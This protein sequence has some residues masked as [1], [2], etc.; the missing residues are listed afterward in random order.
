MFLKKP[1]LIS[2][3]FA[4]LG[5]ASLIGAP[6]ADAGGAPPN[7]KKGEIGYLLPDKSAHV[8]SITHIKVKAGTMYVDPDKGVV[9]TPNGG[10]IASI[11]VVPKHSDG[12]LPA[13][14]HGIIGGIV[15]LVGMLLIQRHNRSSSPS[16]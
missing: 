2:L 12:V 9:E 4:V 5:L 16:S 1:L 8:R 3:A 14:V 10:Y 7:C 11:C 13:L 6:A 15:V